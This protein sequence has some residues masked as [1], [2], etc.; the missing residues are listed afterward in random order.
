[1]NMTKR[2][3]KYAVVLAKEGLYWY[4]DDKNKTNNTLQALKGWQALC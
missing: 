3:Y 1:M 2:K 4:G